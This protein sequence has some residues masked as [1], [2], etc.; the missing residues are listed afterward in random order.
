MFSHVTVLPFTIM[1]AS[2]PLRVLS[3]NMHG[4]NQGSHYLKIFDII[5]LQEHWFY[6]SNRNLL[7]N[8]CPDFVCF[9][10]SAMGKHVD[11]SFNGLPLGGMAIL[12]STGVAVNCQ[13]IC[14]A[15]RYI[16]IIISKHCL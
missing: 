9:S 1:A 16:I 11:H 6:L 7:C 13:L 15:D 14:T 8:L 12:M 3:Y 4:F 5:F 10:C 2:H